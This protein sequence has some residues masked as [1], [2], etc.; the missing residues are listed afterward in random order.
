MMKKKLPPYFPRLFPSSRNFI[1][2]PSSFHSYFVT[3]TIFK[4]CQT[5]TRTNCQPI[6]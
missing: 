4:L 1:P 3:L 6:R 2:L 5:R